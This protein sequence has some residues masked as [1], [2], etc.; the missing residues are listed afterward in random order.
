MRSRVTVSAGSAP[1]TTTDRMLRRAGR[2]AGLREREDD[3]VEPEREADARRR[4]A[5]QQLDQA[6]IAAAAAERRLLALDALAVELER[7]PRVVVE[8]A[9]EPWRQPVGDA[10]RVEVGAGRPRSG[11]A[12][13]AQ[14]VGDGRSRGDELGQ[15]GVLGVEQPQGVR[16]QALALDA[17]ESVLVRRRSGRAGCSM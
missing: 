3:A 2:H 13:V 11:R 14:V 16:G 10:Q 1:Q 5:A 12:G 7:G 15:V 6:V 9:H 8:A 17:D 4:L